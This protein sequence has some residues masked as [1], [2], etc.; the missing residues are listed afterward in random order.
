MAPCT[1]DERQVLLL[2]C[3]E[4]QSVLDEE[5]RTRTILNDEHRKKTEK[6]ELFQFLI[7]PWLDSVQCLCSCPW[8]PNSG[9]PEGD[10]VEEK[11]AHRHG[12]YT[13]CVVR[14]IKYTFSTVLLALCLN[15]IITGIF[16][17]A[18]P[19]GK[20]ANSLVAFSTMW[21]LI[22]WLG[23]LEGGQGCLVGLQ[24]IDKELYAKTHPMTH[25]C[26]TIAH[27]GDNLNRFIVGRQ[28]LVVLVV[29][30]LNLCCTMVEGA[31]IPGFSN[32]L[33]A[34]FLSSGIAVMLITVVLGQLS[35]EVN[36]TN[37]MLDF[38]NTPVMVCTTWVCL[39][40]ESSGLLHSVYLVQCFFSLFTRKGSETQ[41]EPSR[42][43]MQSLFFWVRV[44]LSL[45][46]LCYALTVTLA[47]LLEDKTTMCQG[48]P[49]VSSVA[50]F[51]CLICMLGMLEAMQIALFAVVNLPSE[52]LQEHPVAVANCQLVFSD[53]NFK[54]FLIG[55]QIWVTTCMF[56]LARITTTD[57]DT[58]GPGDGNVLNVSS[59]I[60]KFFNTG[61]PGA[62]ITTIVASLVWR[63]IAS[64]FPIAFM[65]NPFVR[66]TI[67]LCL[68]LEAS[69][70]FSAAW[71]LG[72]IL[73][74]VIGLKPDEVYIG[75]SGERET[76]E[77]SGE[78][79]G[80]ALK[81]HTTKTNY[82]ATM[83]EPVIIC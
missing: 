83:D 32:G 31:V 44:L 67:R 60:Q 3:G 9:K 37:C 16:A 79:E 35:A 5:S 53:D 20:S 71:L 25:Q 14:I 49:D 57:V 42:T 77:A 78:E 46:L 69:G 47:A 68:L 48:L 58:D 7:R 74:L 28:F 45:T 34:V 63:I 62:L 55:R 80:L 12:I 8:T 17:E 75:T 27:K 18:T 73:K 4:E 40:I 65:A 64:S 54:A 41:D 11:N 52:D 29:F 10:P 66:V 61:L 2:S 22:L 72:D 19:I 1:I 23:V 81:D 13:A 76:R 6:S 56:L 15:M 82:G 21:I 70:V 30:C 59:A 33:V 24:P 51:I 50:I 38:I 36:A 39:A 26:A 43:N